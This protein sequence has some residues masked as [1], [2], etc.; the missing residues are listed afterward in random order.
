MSELIILA[1]VTRITAIFSILGSSAIIHMVISDRTHKI[2]K[3]SHRILFLMSVFDVIQSSAGAFSTMPMPKNPDYPGS[4]GNETTCTIQGF[5]IGLGLAVPLYNSSLNLFFLLSIRYNIDPKMFSRKIEP[6]L[7]AISILIPLT[8][9]ITFTVTGNMKPRK[10]VCYPTSRG[11]HLFIVALVILCMLFCLYSMGGIC[12]TVYSQNKSMDKYVF[13][14]MNNQ[15]TSPRSN[16]GLL[17]SDRET[18]KQAVMYTCA[19]FLTYTF[20]IISAMIWK[21]GT[22]NPIPFWIAFLSNTFYPLQGFWNF[23]FYVRPGINYV[24]ETTDKSFLAAVREVVFNSKGL[25]MQRRISPRS[26]S[27]KN[28]SRM[29]SPTEGHRCL[30]KS[31]DDGK[32]N[33]S[34]TEGVLIDIENDHVKLEELNRETRESIQKGR[35]E[36]HFESLDLESRINV[37]HEP[38]V[39]NDALEDIDQKCN[40]QSGRHEQ[41]RRISFANLASVLSGTDFE[42]L[43]SY[44]NDNSNQA[45]RSKP[46]KVEQ[47]KPQRRRSLPIFFPTILPHTEI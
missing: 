16:R 31:D 21:G 37:N 10:A 22:G 45:R 14:R 9:S 1:W 32:S 5:F 30:S 4:M 29:C 23:M 12:W 43:V 27:R 26:V 35:T 41:E 24:L 34:I 25:S 36:R 47:E 2:T 33:R 38:T 20:P 8:I 28:C 19:F 13:R 15:N 44:D 17:S 7:H 3:P 39:D 40:I 6:F 46:Q 42:S 11:G 18:L